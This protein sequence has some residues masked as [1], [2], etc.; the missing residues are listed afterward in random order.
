MLERSVHPESAH[1]YNQKFRWG[2]S[3]RDNEECQRAFLPSPAVVRIKSVSFFL[4]TVLRNWITLTVSADDV[5]FFSEKSFW[6]IWYWSNKQT[7]VWL[8]VR[9]DQGGKADFLDCLE[10]FGT[11]WY[12][13]VFLGT[14]VLL[15]SRS[16]LFPPCHLHYQHRTILWHYCVTVSHRYFFCVHSNAI[17]LVSELGGSTRFTFVS[18]SR[19]KT[20]IRHHLNM[21]CFAW[22][23]LFLSSLLPGHANLGCS[24]SSVST[25]TCFLLL[26]L[27]PSN[28]LFL[29][30]SPHRSLY[31]DF[32]LSLYVTSLVCACVSVRWSEK[33]SF[34]FTC[35]VYFLKMAA[36][37]AETSK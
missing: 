19:T 37:T 25:C 6:E 4:F 31:L 30:C 8:L 15:E 13:L 20:K 33:S 27:Y 12:F 7:N 29:C 2:E 17:F 21:C 23:C 26:S 18:I 24:S 1:A 34:S 10:L 16:P 3:N 9:F 35:A 32:S 36:K 14:S 22:S 5:L 28:C 11:S